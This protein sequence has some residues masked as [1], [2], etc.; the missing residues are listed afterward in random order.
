MS[1]EAPRQVPE[2]SPLEQ[3]QFAREVLR[4]EGD[5]ILALAER[6]GE[7]FLQAVGLLAGCRGNVIVT[8]MGKAGL[9]GRKIA[10]TLASTGTSSH[11]LHPSE[12]VHGD[13]GRIHALDLVLALSFSGETA[14]L[15][16]LLTSLAE[17][18]TSVVAVTG[19]A[20][21]T[22]GRKAGITLELGA[23][24][25][26]CFLGLAPTTST[27][28]MLALGDALALVISRLKGFGRGDFARFHP[29]GNLGRKL[30]RVEEVMRPLHECRVSEQAETVRDV[31]IK[32]SRPGRR[33]GAIMLVDTDGCLTGLFTDSDLARMLEHGRESALDA[34]ISQVMTRNPTTVPPRTFLQEATELLAEKKISELPVVNHEL[35]PL[36]MIDIT[37]L[38]G[39][40][41][42][43][44]DPSAP[45]PSNP[46]LEADSWRAKTFRFPSS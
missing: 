24:Q 25:E 33:T 7:E 22:L 46:P 42:R 39:P 1:T 30:A 11:F 4:G 10:A 9:V 8:G 40:T 28:V 16:R 19:N 32:V 38:L 37:D 18:D 23:I 15:T 3:L 29:G 6:L 44:A 5:A 26:A 31:L 35:R 14:E 13:L 21:S 36:G 12:A 27:T 43:V 2:F 34:P 45:I 17:L 20:C 41:G